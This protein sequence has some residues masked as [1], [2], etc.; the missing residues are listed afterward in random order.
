RS[1]IAR[2]ILV[3]AFFF[4]IWRPS[5]FAGELFPSSL[6]IQATGV[7][8]C[9]AGITFAIWARYI[10]GTNWSRNPEIK[11]GHEL[12]TAGPYR[13]VRHPIY[14]GIILAILGSSLVDGRLRDLV[15]L[16]MVTLAFFMRSRIEERLMMRQFPEAYSEYK[17]NVKS[18]IPFVF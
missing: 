8:L 10:L 16:A 4:L 7:V 1:L 13:F 2:T 9:A 14:T 3:I 15:L 12:V 18:L 11:V 17:K 6:V 5:F